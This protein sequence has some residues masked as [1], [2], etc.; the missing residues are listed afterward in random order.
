MI[1]II[2]MTPQELLKT[3][4]AKAKAKRLSLDLSQRTLSE[5]S[6]VS[7]GVLKKFER[8][9]QISLE[10]LLKLALSLGSLSDFEHVFT[11]RNPMEATSLAE[12]M[13]D[14]TRKRGRK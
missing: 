1:S 9:G 13:E 7:Y 5:R 12:L 8:T 4:A 11:H 2:M 10:S 6:G 3:I 14:T